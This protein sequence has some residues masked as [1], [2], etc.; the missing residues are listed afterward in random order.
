MQSKI[1]RINDFIGMCDKFISN[2]RYSE[3]YLID[4][5]SIILMKEASISNA[6]NYLKA[7]ASMCSNTK[8]NLKE[9]YAFLYTNA[10]MGVFRDNEKFELLLNSRNSVSHSSQDIAE[11]LKLPFTNKDLIE[12]IEFLVRCCKSYNLTAIDLNPLTIDNT[13]Q[14]I[15][16]NKVINYAN[17]LKYPT[18]TELNKRL[19]TY[20]KNVTD[21]TTWSVLDG[22]T[23][24]DKVIDLINREIPHNT[25]KTSKMN[26]F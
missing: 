18:N 11:L 25:N 14:K 2:I 19:I 20:I 13:L 1:F 7:V 22:T 9:C 17:P 10:Y 5:L 6:S 15:N 3:D 21:A 8:A 12:L 23:D 26:L 16:E 24:K 4:E